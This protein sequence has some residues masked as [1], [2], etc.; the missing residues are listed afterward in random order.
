[1]IARERR[2]AS[3]N[4]NRNPSCVTKQQAFLLIKLIRS[5]LL[6]RG[7]HMP[8]RLLLLLLFFFL[9]CVASRRAV[10]LRPRRA[11]DCRAVAQLLILN[12][13]PGAGGN[14]FI[15][16]LALRIYHIQKST[17]TDSIV[18]TI[19]TTTAATTGSA[20]Y[21]STIV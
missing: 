10:R 5:W 18:A 11:L 3:R 1:M 12:L 17:K 15:V 9:H 14:H 13:C 19:T 20:P 7:C 2:E 16:I 4:S 6:W 21:G 8:Q